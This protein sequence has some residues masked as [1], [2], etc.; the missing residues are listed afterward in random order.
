MTG[1][2]ARRGTAG[3]A[4]FTLVMV[5]VLLAGL[6]TPLRSGRLP[7]GDCRSALVIGAEG[8]GLR[9]LVRETCDVL[10]RIPIAPSVDSLNVAAAAAI[11][12]YECRR[13]DTIA[14][15]PRGWPA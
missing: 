15:S 14:S 8:S 1:R 2:S 4:I 6:V 13:E 3:F 11:A 9:R 7:G 5:A 10:V 12:L